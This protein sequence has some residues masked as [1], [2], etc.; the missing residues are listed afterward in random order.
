MITCFRYSDTMSSRRTQ[1]FRKMLTKGR[2]QGRAPSILMNPAGGIRYH[3]RALR[4][5]NRQWQSFRW[6]IG[7]WL[8]GWQPKE[9]TLLLVGPSAGYCLQPFF[10]ERFE[11]VICLE[12]DPVARYLFKRKLMRAPLEPRPQLEFIAEDCLV[13][14]PERPTKIGRTPIRR[15]PAI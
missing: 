4:F 5:G 15:V 12:P 10:F 2:A 9:P 6:E 11:R 7:E 3:W 1:K 13:R 8:L 14:S